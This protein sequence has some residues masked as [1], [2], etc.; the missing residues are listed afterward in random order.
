METG[1][2]LLIV[3]V[4]Y[5]FA[6]SLA[7]SFKF[8]KVP[9]VLILV[10]AGIIVGPV[11]GIADPADF[12]RMGPVLAVIAL[13]IILFESGTSLTLSTLASSAKATVLVTFV[14][15]LVTMII[16]AFLSLGFVGGDW[17]LAFLT[18]AILSGTSSSVVIPM[19]QSMNL[20][21]KASA[22]MVLESALTD[23]ICILLPFTLMESRI[24]GTVS[25]YGISLQVVISLAVAV[26]IG[27]AG[28]FIWSLVWNKVR[29]L[30]NSVFTTIAFAFVLYGLSELFGVSGAIATL[31]FGFTLANLPIFFKSK[32]FPQITLEERQFYH[33]IIFLLKTFFF[34]FLGVSIR[35]S[36]PLVIAAS[37]VALVV[38][39]FARGFIVRMFLPKDGVDVR[40]ASVVAIMIPKGLPPAVLASI[41]VQRGLPNAANIQAIVYSVIVLSIVM[42]AVLNPL[43]E[44]RPVKT[45]YS[46]LLKNFT[47]REE[48]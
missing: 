1:V 15:S 11:L 2:I 21:E 16:M 48:S 24:S 45:F 28:G 39:Y 27:I 18:G 33:E 17:G 23:V 4:F 3:G 29:K 19:V 9:D 14:T 41:V 25:F 46:T 10:V 20:G 32:S 5:F 6:H 47:A 35:I 22:V 37:A 26:V 7:F 13:A 12:G 31:A 30:P 38:I 40:D 34:V 44:R 36:N 43:L 8:T 42:T